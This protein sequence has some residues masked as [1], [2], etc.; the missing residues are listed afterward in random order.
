MSAVPKIKAVLISDVHFNLNTKDVAAFSIREA[1]RAA[2]KYEVPLIICGDIHDTK[3]HMRAECVNAMID[4]IKTCNTEIF[5]LVGNHDKINEKSHEHALE[6]LN[7]Y[8]YVIDHHIYLSSLDMYF[9]SYSSDV[10]VTKRLLADIPNPSIVIMHQGFNGAHGGEYYN[11]PTALNFSD[12]KGL[13]VISGHYHRRQTIERDGCKLS[14][15]GNPYTLTFAEVQD[16]EKGF[17]LLFDDGTLSFVPIGARKHV[18]T[19][20]RAD[21]L[22]AL[23]DAALSSVDIHMIQVFA[24]N[25]E[26]ISFERKKLSSILGF[27]NYRLKF[28]PLDTNPQVSTTAATANNA[29]T[30][31]KAVDQSTLRPPEKVEVKEVIEVFK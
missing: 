25:L 28:M 18:I 22:E 11:D 7:P 17:Q 23:K 15:V 26:I 16:P 1:A 2:N 30:I 13:R 10:K 14:Y 20:V 12:A 9:F 31:L 24:T 6:F 8:A 29:E 19:Q 4:S 5:I 27:N 21:N 3:A